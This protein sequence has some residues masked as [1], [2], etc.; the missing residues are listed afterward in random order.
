M[1]EE[2]GGFFLAIV[3][4]KIHDTMGGK[5]PEDMGG[6][7]PPELGPGPMGPATDMGGSGP[8]SRSWGAGARCPSWAVKDLTWK[9]EGCEAGAGVAWDVLAQFHWATPANKRE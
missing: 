5:E 1:K 6:N 4:F 7:G 3:I 9:Y 8:S 2:F